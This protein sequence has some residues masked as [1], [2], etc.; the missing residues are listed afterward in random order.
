MVGRPCFRFYSHLAWTANLD[1]SCCKFC[2]LPPATA[3]VSRAEPDGCRTHVTLGVR[4]P[5]HTQHTSNRYGCSST[6]LAS[7]ECLTNR[8]RN[9]MNF[10]PHWTFKICVFI[11]R[12]VIWCIATKE[13][14]HLEYL[15]ILKKL[16]YKTPWQDE[17]F[18]AKSSKSTIHIF[19]H[20]WSALL[21][22]PV[23]IF[24]MVLSCHISGN[25]ETMI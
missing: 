1:C 3:S 20:E 7:W 10:V 12:I 25:R 6:L 24:F 14:I 23:L 5:K 18:S 4:T 21:S 17:L 19:A 11:E 9:W 8:S 15:Y 13:N 16:H 2:T 22:W